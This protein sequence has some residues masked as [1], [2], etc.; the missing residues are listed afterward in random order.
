M[1]P[2]VLYCPI[3]LSRTEQKNWSVNLNEYRNTHHQTLNKMKVR[4]K[5]T[6]EDQI[7]LLPQFK[8]VSIWYKLFYPNERDIDT[9]NFTSIVDKFLCD[10]LKEFGVIEDDNR[11]F[12]IETRSTFG[13]VDKRNPRCEAHITGEIKEMETM[14]IVLDNTEVMDAVTALVASDRNLIA[15]AVTEHLGRIVT[16]KEGQRLEVAMRHSKD[17]GWTASAS[18]VPA[19]GNTP[20]SQA[21]AA[22]GHITGKLDQDVLP[23]VQAT[24]EPVQ[25]PFEGVP[26]G[27]EFP[28]EEP[29]SDA[30]DTSVRS[31][32]TLFNLPGAA[33]GTNNG[34]DTD[35][36]SAPEEEAPQEAPDPQPEQPKPLFKLPFPKG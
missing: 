17:D 11:K 5:E 14:K 24:P 8:T 22:Q 31:A 32:A 10:A 21:V 30:P 36:G 19:E 16:L 7:K 29:A 27:T 25:A 6:M 23:T 13:G 3:F 15:R 4:F 35:G 34:A 33:S 2:L 20:L 12:V 18:L 26:S 1:T 9:A 28:A